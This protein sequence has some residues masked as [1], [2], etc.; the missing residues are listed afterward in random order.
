MCVFV[1]LCVCDHVVDVTMSSTFALHS[2]CPVAVLLRSVCQN[3]P[4][5]F[6]LK[7]FGAADWSVVEED[8]A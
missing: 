7:S 3:P 4:I 1:C 8:I 5:E 2:F 6:H